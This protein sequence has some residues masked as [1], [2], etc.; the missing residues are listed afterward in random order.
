M[1]SLRARNNK[2]LFYCPFLAKAVRR[3]SA[4]DFVEELL[5]FV[6]EAPACAFRDPESHVAAIDLHFLVALA[7]QP[8]RGALRDD[9]V[10]GGPDRERR[11]RR[12]L[13][14]M[15]QRRRI[16][17]VACDPLV[18]APDVVHVRIAGERGSQGHHGPDELGNFTGKLPRIDSTEAPADHQDGAAVVDDLQ[19]LPQ[20]PQYVRV[21]PSVEPEVPRKGPPSG[22]SERVTKTGAG[23]VRREEAR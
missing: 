12:L 7:V 23:A 20:M 19:P 4:S 2:P 15:R 16:N 6:P 18:E 22:L 8:A 17:L 11:H 10:P 21:G 1:V 5:H 14:M 3:G 13:G 9:A